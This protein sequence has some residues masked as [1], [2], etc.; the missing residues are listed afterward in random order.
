[1]MIKLFFLLKRGRFQ[2]K[3]TLYKRVWQM[4]FDVMILFYVFVFIGYI[5]WAVIHE[6]NIGERMSQF[7]FQLEAISIT[8]FWMI[9]TVIPIVLLLRTFTRPGIIIS[10]AEYMATM[11]TFTKKQIW[12]MAT[13]ERWIKLA[14]ILSFIGTGL[15]L[16]SPMSGFVIILYIG[17]L[18]GLNILMTVIEWRVFQLHII[19][20]FIITLLAISINV[21][22]I[23]TSPPIIAT[24]VLLC[25]IFINLLLLPRV[26]A[27]IDWKKVTTA[28]DYQIWNMA[29][30][31]YMTKQRMKKERAYTIWQRMP[32]WRKAFSYNKE[33]A[34]HRLWYVY[35][36]RQIVIVLQF[37]GAMLLLVSFIPVT[38]R[39]IIPLM[40]TFGYSMSPLKDWFFLIALVVA[41]HMYVSV[42]VIIWRDRLTTDIMHVLPWDVVALQKSYLKWVD[43]GSMIFIIPIYLYGLE[44]FSL[45][46]ILQM[47]IALFVLLFLLFWKI[48]A[49][50]QTISEREVFHIPKQLIPFGYTLLIMMIVSEFIP[51]MILITLVFLVLVIASHYRYR[52]Q[53]R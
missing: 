14:I 12:W 46:F 25:L 48:V 31:G 26:D 9:I 51:Y 42:A 19:W 37:T 45:L 33:K 30:I 40:D 35:F 43:T 13:F 52:K 18:F 24:A 10:T 49:A 28:C 17:L 53:V 20:K 11:L 15:L 8:Y 21:I 22:S 50:F 38:N 3:V 16:L 29:L 32:F 5:V 41:I 47:I 36:Q 6:G 44:H 7:A 4:S 34:Y 2:K 23:M 39:W 1:M 27:K